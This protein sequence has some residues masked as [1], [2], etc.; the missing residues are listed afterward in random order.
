[1]DSFC[2]SDFRSNNFRVCQVDDFYCVI[3]SRRLKVR[4]DVLS[5]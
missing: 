1:M 2:E 3:G 4:R 5:L